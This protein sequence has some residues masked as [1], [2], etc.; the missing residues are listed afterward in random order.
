MGSIRLV[1]RIV[2]RSVLKNL[3]KAVQGIAEFLDAVEDRYSFS[4]CILRRS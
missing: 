3:L 4:Y 2:E 1:C